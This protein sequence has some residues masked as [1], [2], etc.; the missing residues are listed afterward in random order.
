MERSPIKDT[1]IKQ[2]LKNALTEKINDR[3]IY[4]KGA[5]IYYNL[6]I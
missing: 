2:V 1:E 6:M 4:M 5:Y 3:E